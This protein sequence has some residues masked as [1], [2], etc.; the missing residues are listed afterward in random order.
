VRFLISGAAKH[1]AILDT[2]R[3]A[4]MPDEQ[5]YLRTTFF[6]DLAQTCFSDIN[7][8]ISTSLSAQIH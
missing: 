1:C 4:R 6:P 3:P 5:R 8:L 7:S 2:T